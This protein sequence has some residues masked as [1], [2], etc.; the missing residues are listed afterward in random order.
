MSWVWLCSSEVLE[1]ITEPTRSAA[2]LARGRVTAGVVFMVSSSLLDGQTLFH[3]GEP[4]GTRGGDQDCFG[5]LIA[6]SVH[7]HAEDDVEGHPGLQTGGLLGA[8]ADRALAPVRW[9][10]DPDGVP[11]PGLLDQP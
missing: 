9:K 11:D 2:R 4:F 3:I 7:P 8:E 6:P 10:P 1:S 5:H